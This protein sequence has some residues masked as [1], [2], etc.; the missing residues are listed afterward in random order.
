MAG[1]G[2][3]SGEIREIKIK[4]PDG[5][6]GGRYSNM[7]G[8]QHTATEFIM[9]F[10]FVSGGV[11][12][13]VARVITSPSHMKRIIAALQENVARYEH[14]FGKIKEAGEPQVRLGF[15]PPE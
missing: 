10:A 9:D 5:V 8:V 6:A 3:T 11:G 1:R 13:V 15:H 4:I 2:E 12:E 14:T 7:M